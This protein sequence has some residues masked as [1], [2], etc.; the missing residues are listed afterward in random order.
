MHG[1]RPRLS[2][3]F[4]A[5]CSFSLNLASSMKPRRRLRSGWRDGSTFDEIAN[6]L[7]KIYRN[8]ALVVH[9]SEKRSLDVLAKLIDTAI[10]IFYLKHL[11][12]N[13]YSASIYVKFLVLSTVFI[14][15][16]RHDG[17]L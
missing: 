8:I 14:R 2:R 17:V 15:P 9:N 10:S 7:I 13:A 4:A 1:S 16:R 6:I 3:G 11:E 12:G 5:A